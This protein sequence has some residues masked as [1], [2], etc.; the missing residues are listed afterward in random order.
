[1]EEKKM[2]HLALD[3]LRKEFVKVK[4][5]GTS[6]DYDHLCICHGCGTFHAVR[7]SFL[8]LPQAI[9]FTFDDGSMATIPA[10]SCGGCPTKAIRNAFY[11]GMTDAA[12]KAAEKKIGSKAGGR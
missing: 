3:K 8:S 11:H 10:H 12:R 2:S 5:N 1:M 6:N 4:D 9:G 7:C